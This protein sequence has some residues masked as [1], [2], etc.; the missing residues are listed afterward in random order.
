MLIHA[1]CQQ[2]TEKPFTVTD[3]KITWS[4]IENLGGSYTSSWKISNTGEST[5]PD[6]G[7]TIYYNQVGGVPVPESL[8]GSLQ[9][10]LVNGTLYRIMPKASFKSLGAGEST[11]T[12][13]KCYGSVIKVTDAPAG[14]YIIFD[15]QQGP[16]RLENYDIG[17]FLQPQQIN[18]SDGDN[19]PIDRKSTR[20]NSS[21]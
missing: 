2:Q 19:V 17:P 15:D 4:V 11:R 5:F 3:L 16:Q 13:L 12:D 20:L 8:S 6:S 10:T 18:R 7:W 14:L 1:S 9:I 21:H